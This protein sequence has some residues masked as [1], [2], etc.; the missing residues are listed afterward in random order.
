MQAPFI[1]KNLCAYFILFG[2]CFAW[3][4]ALGQLFL[5][6]RFLN[7]KILAA[8]FFLLGIYQ[9]SAGLF[10][11]DALKGIPFNIFAISVPCFVLCVPLLF[12]YFN[13]LVDPQFSFGPK[14]GLHFI[15][16]AAALVLIGPSFQRQIDLYHLMNLV[17]IHPEKPEGMMTAVV[18]YLAMGVLFGYLTHSLLFVTKVLKNARFPERKIVGTCRNL[19]LAM[20]GIIVFWFADRLLS[21]GFATVAYVFTSFVL[22]YLYVL[23]NRHP[24]YLLIFKI[25]AELEKY[26]RPR[27]GDMDKRVI[28]ESIR[29]LL[30]QEKIY[31]EEGLS[32]KSFAQKLSI[33]AHQL[34]EI[35]NCEFKQNF[36]TLVNGHRIEEAKRLLKADPDMKII[37]VAFDVGFKSPSAFYNAFQKMTGTT[38]ARYREQ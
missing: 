6:E 29:H 5:K 18:M 8:Y 32:L 38:P 30:Q 20:M 10:Y 2:G 19:I 9:I 36:Y 17:Q 1:L 7:N 37:G 21:L 31:K 27:T 26:K 3:V 15:F 14:T 4:L 35:I 11:M 34:S 33:T 12:F 28:V 22:V 24:E 16:P 13:C 25:E 23:S